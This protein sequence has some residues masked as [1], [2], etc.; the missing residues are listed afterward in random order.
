MEIFILFWLLLSA[1][2]GYLA[3]ER[4]RSGVGWALLSVVTSPLL[5]LI[6]VLIARDL[7]VEAADR[8]RDEKRHREQLAALSNDRS[9]QPAPLAWPEEA[10]RT[11]PIAQSKSAQKDVPILVAD[12]LQKLAALVDRGLLTSEEFAEQK[13]RLLGKPSV[14]V[15]QPKVEDSSEY[16]QLLASLATPLKCQ[17]FLV[18]RGCRVTRP[19]EHVW[20]VLQPSGITVYARSPEALQTMAIQIARELSARQA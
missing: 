3:S 2:V 4:G 15:E 5:G 10:V 13:S 6:I 7:V 12:E 19:T 1:G 9:L 11:D 16:K 14:P 8:E 17:Y 20:E 18:S